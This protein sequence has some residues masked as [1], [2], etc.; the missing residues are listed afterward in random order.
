ML[1]SVYD[2]IRLYDYNKKQKEHIYSHIDTF[3]KQY[4]LGIDIDYIRRVS[5]D[6]NN[7][8]LFYNLNKSLSK[9]SIRNEIVGC[10]I[11]RIILNQP[12]KKR[13]YI[14]LLSVHYKVRGLGY[15][16]N[17]IDAVIEKHKREKQELEVVLLSLPSSVEF[18]KRLGFIESNSKFIQNHEYIEDNVILC[19]NY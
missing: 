11:Y 4:C 13:I 6:C 9:Y 2:I 5:Y 12:Y 19:K 8:I 18:Y 10:I 1:V 15:G 17:I 7:T 3:I 14:S 16:Q